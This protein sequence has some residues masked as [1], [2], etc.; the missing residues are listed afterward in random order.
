[1]T[2]AAL[3]Q[4]LLLYGWFVLSAL[5]L[6]LLAIARFYQKFSG[7]RTHFHWF[8]MPIVLYGIGAVRYASIDQI[9]HDVLADGVL[10]AAGAIVIFLSLRLYHL[11]THG[12]KEP[13]P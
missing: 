12:R 5:L 1:M 2:T 4:V 13:T 11:M 7:E 9:A 3:S 10:G 8:I 6:F